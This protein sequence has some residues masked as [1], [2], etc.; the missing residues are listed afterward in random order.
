MTE[1]KSQIKSQIMKIYEYNF[2]NIDKNYYS[3]HITH[4][5]IVY[6][7][8]NFQGPSWFLLT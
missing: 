1:F 2:L 5:K 6:L 7:I 3:V 4:L 8:S